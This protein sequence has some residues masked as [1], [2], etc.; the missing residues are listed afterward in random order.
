MKPSAAAGSSACSIRPRG[1]AQHFQREAELSRVLRT[2]GVQGSCAVAR[3][4]LFLNTHPA[5][6]DDIKRLILSLRSLR[7]A[8]RPTPGNLLGINPKG[9]FLSVGDRGAA[10]PWFSAG[11]RLA[12][13]RGHRGLDWRAPPWSGGEPWL[14]TGTSAGVSS[15]E[16]RRRQRQ[17]GCCWQS[18]GIPGEGIITDVAHRRVPDFGGIAQLVRA[19]A[20]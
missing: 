5:E 16:C 10:L 7:T 3:P 8:N 9:T 17:P 19:T 14:R 13:M 11:R 18:A 2:V 1:F 12:K 6:L 20:S 15:F 4:H